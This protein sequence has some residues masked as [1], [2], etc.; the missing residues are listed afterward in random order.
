MDLYNQHPI[1]TIYSHAAQKVGL[2]S[3]PVKLPSTFPT[4]PASSVWGFSGSSV[5]PSLVSSASA[6]MAEDLIWSR[7]AAGGRKSQCSANAW[8]WWWRCLWLRYYSVFFPLSNSLRNRVSLNG[9][10]LEIPDVIFRFAL[11]TSDF[12]QQKQTITKHVHIHSWSLHG[13]FAINGQWMSMV[14]KYFFHTLKWICTT[15]ILSRQFT[16]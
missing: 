13:W 14:Y 4:L 16:P 8:W 12:T 10:P 3:F 6:W 2:N 1:P 11:P 9:F 5:F 7:W 15:N